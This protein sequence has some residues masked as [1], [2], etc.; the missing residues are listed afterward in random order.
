MKKLSSKAIFLILGIILFIAIPVFSV[1]SEKSVE[2]NFF[3]SPSC[4]HCIKENKF[5]DKLGEKY[6]EIKINRYSISNPENVEILKGFCQKCSEAQPYLGSV[7]LTF[8]GDDFIPG[9][10][11]E[12][13]IGIDIENAVRKQLGYPLIQEGEGSIKIPL[14]GEIN[15]KS[16]SLP[17][18]AAALGFLDGFNVCSLGAL[19]LIL[20]LV[21]SLRSRIKI[22]IF[23]GSYIFITALVYGFLIFLWYQLFT[24]LASY[25]TL[26][27]VIVGL[28]GMGGGIY[29]LKQFIKYRKQG[30]SCE[31]INEGPVSRMFSRT[32]NLM[33]NPRSILIMVTSI[34]LF[35]IVIT[36]VEFPCSAVIPVF[37][38]SIL[39]KAQI[40]I[41]YYFFYLCI[42]LFFYMLDE[43]IVFLAALFTL[44]LWLTSKKFI[45][46][47]TLFEAFMFFSLG[48]YYFTAIFK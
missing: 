4:P 17:I 42:Y 22:L 16:Y 21:L 45:T 38:A 25:M 26:I 47:I 41:F 37:F 7:P 19:V 14:L 27:Q 40:S 12:K 33:E 32:K 3:Y 18:Q 44:N 5:L 39:A 11:N 34:I 9:F 31:I 43:I 46:W 1:Y 8:I 6:P 24:L 20:G 48:I 29:F 23:G 13:N 15:I 35:A 28:L 36:V 2:I 10:D 30:P